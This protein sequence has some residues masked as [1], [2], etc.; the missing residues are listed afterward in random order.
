MSA[1]RRTHYLL[2]FQYR[3]VTNNYNR[4]PLLLVYWKKSCFHDIT[5]EPPK[6]S[7]IT[8]TSTSRHVLS[9]LLLSYDH[10]I[11]TIVRVPIDSNYYFML[12]TYRT[13]SS[14]AFQVIVPTFPEF[15][16]I[17]ISDGIHV[18]FDLVGTLFLF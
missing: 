16:D 8:S 7:S 12:M 14:E 3:N 10:I 1:I 15:I 18:K 11:E 5:V 13:T 4:T 6:C 9:G 2:I 17:A